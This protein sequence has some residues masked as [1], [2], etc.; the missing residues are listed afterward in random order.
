M[1]PTFSISSIFDEPIDTNT[2]TLH[3][4]FG[5][6]GTFAT[7]HILQNQ[8]D[9]FMVELPTSFCD[10]EGEYWFS[11]ATQD[12]LTVR[13]PAGE[14][15][16]RV[17]IAA[18]ARQWNMDQNPNWTMEGQWG[19][20]VPTGGGGSYGNPD[21]TS[22]ATGNNV[23][24]YNLNGDYQNNLS[25]IHLT[26]E[27]VD[28]SD[29]TN[30]QLQFK[31]YLNVEQPVYDHAS[32]SVRAG[33]GSWSTVWSNQSTIEDD[34]WQTVAYDISSVADAQPDVQIR[35]TMGTTDSAWTYSGWNIDDIEILS[36]GGAGVVGDVNCDGIINV[37]DILLVVG[38]WG[39]CNDHCAEDII[40]DGTINVLDLLHVIGNW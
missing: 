24:G 18:T 25:E 23:L 34:Q 21:P 8:D 6:T 19:W 12:G 15:V 37:T 36:S 31:R 17:S 4:R 7:R 20:G 16:L 9:S 13:Y 10:L 1:P 22:G 2:T 28:L 39:P 27:T 29:R 26:T 5:N 32:V 30:T 35:W 3:V 11:V 14:E 40:P 33:A 38:G